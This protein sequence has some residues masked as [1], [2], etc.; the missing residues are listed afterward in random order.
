MAGTNLGPYGSVASKQE[1]AALIRAWQERQG[2]PDAPQD[3]PLKANERVTINEMVLVYLK[4]AITYYRM[5]QGE[6]K[7]AGCISDALAIMQDLYGREYADEFRPKDLP[8]PAGKN[9][10]L[11]RAVWSSLRSG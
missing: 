7:E 10:R 6:N 5:N 2:Q 9:N 1:Y 11:T 3:Q 4:H 8:P